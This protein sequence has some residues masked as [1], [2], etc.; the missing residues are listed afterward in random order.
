MPG[1]VIFAPRC[2]GVDPQPFVRA[3]HDLLAALVWP[4]TSPWYTS[5]P[6][7]PPSLT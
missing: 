2:G 3:E 6:V 1:N 4:P 7:F 5:I